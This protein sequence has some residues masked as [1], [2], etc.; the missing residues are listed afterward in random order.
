MDTGLT[1]AENREL[2]QR[3]Q[4]R[5]V[6]E[7]MNVFGSLVDNC[8]TSCVDDFTSKAMSNR[9]NGCISRCVLKSMS[10][11]TRLGERFGELNAAMAQEMQK[12]M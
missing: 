5:Q 8:F 11:Q 2:E 7:F 1:Q 3:L 6:K 12:R 9:E 4:K 10:T